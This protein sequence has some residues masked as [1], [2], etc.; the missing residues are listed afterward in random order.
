MLILKNGYL[1]EPESGYEGY[2]DILID[3][4]KIVDIVDKGCGKV[5]KL[6]HDSANEVI[7]VAGKIVTRRWFPLM[8]YSYV[9]WVRDIFM[10]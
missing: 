8:R 1:I 5:E 3:G 6:S 7:D 10:T 9:R 2:K 4:D